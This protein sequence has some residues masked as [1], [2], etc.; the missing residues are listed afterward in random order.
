MPRHGLAG[1]SW[2]A[3]NV[4]KKLRKRTGNEGLSSLKKAAKTFAH[5]NPEFAPFHILNVRCMDF[6]PKGR[7]AV[8][9]PTAQGGETAVLRSVD[10]LSV[11][12]IPERPLS[13]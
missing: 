11:F 4:R 9:A 1:R 7:V 3:K 10:D 8:F 5:Q 2:H 6:C 12:G 13:R